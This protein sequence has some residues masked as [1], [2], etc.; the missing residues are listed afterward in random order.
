MQGI[1]KGDAEMS[2]RRGYQQGVIEVF[3]ALAVN[4][5][6]VVHSVLAVSRR[7]HGWFARPLLKAAFI[8][9]PNSACH[10][11]RRRGVA[12]SAPHRQADRDR[13]RHLAGHCQLYSQAV[14][15]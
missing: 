13:T 10:M 1:E 5:Q 8:A 9:R 11:R 6:E 15:P 12:P 7:R 4:F 3:Y 2:F 14:G